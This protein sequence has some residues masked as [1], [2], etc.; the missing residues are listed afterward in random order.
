MH[1]NSIK[2]IYTKILYR[3]FNRKKSLKSPSFIVGC[4][5]SG[6]SLLL[7]ILASHP[8]IW[9]ISNETNMFFEKNNYKIFR[10]IQKLNI[11]T[12]KN[13][14]LF[15]VEKT[16]KHITCIE[17]ILSLIPDAKII[18]IV[19][20]GR[21]V[22][23]SHMKRGSSLEEGMNRWINDNLA[24]RPFYNNKNIYLLKYESII[25]NFF[26]SIKNLLAFLNEPYLESVEKYYEN[27]KFF[28]SPVVTKPE[29]YNKSTHNQY[30]NWQI[31]Q[32]IFDSRSQWM[33]LS[34]DEIHRLESM[35][36]QLLSEFNYI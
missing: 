19:R 16:P 30:R 15:W 1:I 36:G 4:G 24:A 31:N 5:H 11:E 27:E 13:K 6:S 12:L 21:D 17:N 23:Y 9:S 34:K 20:D 32:P 22:A 29:A 3:F 33:N 26:F 2:K 18:I 8:N 10:K 7:S 35:G 28:Y 25:E 14:K